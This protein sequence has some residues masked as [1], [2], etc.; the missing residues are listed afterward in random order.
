MIPLRGVV[1]V[2]P[3]SFDGGDLDSLASER[4][5]DDALAPSDR[6]LDVG[7]G[8]PGDGLNYLG[9]RVAVQADTV[10]RRNNVPRLHAGPKRGR[11]FQRRDHLDFVCDPVLADGYA[12]TNKVAVGIL[13][14]FFCAGRPDDGRVI[15]ERFKSAAHQFTDQQRFG[16]LDRLFVDFAHHAPQ[17]L[18]AISPRHGRIPADLI[19]FGGHAGY[20]F[21][22]A[23]FVLQAIKRFLR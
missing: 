19:Q 20:E 22:A 7:T 23:V 16:Q 11:I 18:Y 8:R 17:M 5:L 3:D 4:K 13:V 12:H 1:C 21:N 15:V 2:S 6:E 9:E 10:N 14:E